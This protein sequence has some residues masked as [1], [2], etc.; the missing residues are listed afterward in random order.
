[1]RFWSWFLEVCLCEEWLFTVLVV[2]AGLIALAAV[3]GYCLK[4][5]GAFAALSAVIGGVARVLVIGGNVEQRAG[6]VGSAFLLVFSGV[7]YLFLF[8]ILL[9]R[10]KFLERKRR[11]AEIARRLCYTLPDRENTY[12]RARLNTALQIP[13]ENLNADMGA[14]DALEQPVK[15]EHARVLL[16]K[17]KEAPLSQAERLRIEEMSKALS[18]YLQKESWTIEELRAVNELCASLL[19]LSAKYTV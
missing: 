10:G 4:N 8:A 17:V 5:T 19:K 13:K 14:S 11:R 16:S 12:I 15:L 7:A 1:M 6:F 3:A 2:A 18:L 9:I